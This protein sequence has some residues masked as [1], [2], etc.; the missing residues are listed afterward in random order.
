MS[1]VFF[2]WLI[3]GESI[4]LSLLGGAALIIAGVYLTNRPAKPSLDPC[5]PQ[6]GTKNPIRRIRLDT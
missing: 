5:D 2:G 4:N 6:D 1:G 3:L